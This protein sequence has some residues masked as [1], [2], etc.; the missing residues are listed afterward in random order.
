MCSYWERCEW[1]GT[2]II[3][4]LLHPHVW[5]LRWDDSQNG[6]SWDWP[7]ECLHMCLWILTAWHWVPRGTSRKQIFQE[8][9]AEPVRLLIFHWLS[10]SITSTHFID[11]KQ[12]TTAI[13][14]SLWRHLYSSFWWRSGKI[15]IQKTT[16]DGR[17]RCSHIWVTQPT[18]GNGSPLCSFW[19]MEQLVGRE[20]PNRYKLLSS[21]TL[22][23]WF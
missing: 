22:W 16:W 13:W 15:T 23:K 7:S 8:I 12:V 4:R 3:W 14:A 11:N 1:L 10:Q 17:Y 5:W 2:G 18:T 19:S 21:T 9:K 20:S 6:L